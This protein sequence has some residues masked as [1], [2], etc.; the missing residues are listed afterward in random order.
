[1]GKQD[2][3]TNRFNLKVISLGPEHLTAC[4]ELAEIALKGLWTP[5]LWEKELL[6]PKRLAIGLT[7]HAKLIA[8]ACGWL[9]TDEINITA[10]AVHP[11]HR[12]NGIGEIILK[13]LLKKAHQ[14]GSTKAILEVSQKNIAAIELYKKLGFE[15]V[16]ERKNYYKDGSNAIIQSLLLNF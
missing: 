2:L 7:N 1:M 15:K 6:N 10:I 16:G 12:R 14:V 5:K 13:D 9:I 3:R 8:I 11:K 4:I